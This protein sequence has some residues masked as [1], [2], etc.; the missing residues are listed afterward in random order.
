[1]SAALEA[2]LENAT[3]ANVASVRVTSARHEESVF[4]FEPEP[5]RTT[6]SEAD[7]IAVLEVVADYRAEHKAMRKNDRVSLDV[8]ETRATTYWGEPGMAEIPLKGIRL[9]PP[10]PGAYSAAYCRFPL[11]TYWEGAGPGSDFSQIGECNP[12]VEDLRI[13]GWDEATGYKGIQDLKHLK[14]LVIFGGAR[15]ED[16]PRVEGLEMLDVQLADDTE[17]NRDRVEA[18]YPGAEVWFHDADE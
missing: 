14:K 9:S 5:G 8:D 6:L 17:A 1:M 12:T 10:M 7:L 13:Y 11:L 3:D 4:T 15:V 16:I 2:D 18:L